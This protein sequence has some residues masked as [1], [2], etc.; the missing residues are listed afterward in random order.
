MLIKFFPDGDLLPAL[1]YMDETLDTTLENWINRSLICI[2]VDIRWLTGLGSL[3]WIE[4]LAAVEW[5]IRKP[6]A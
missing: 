5:K 6:K 2:A 4:L 3:V 1:A